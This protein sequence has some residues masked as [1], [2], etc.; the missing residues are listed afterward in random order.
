MGTV[1]KVMF[2]LIILAGGGGIF[3]AISMI[4]AKIDA[5]KEAKKKSDANV[6]IYSSEATKLEQELSAQQN[7]NDNLRQTNKVLLEKDIPELKKLIETEQGKAKK[8]EEERAAAVGGYDKMKKKY[9]E[10]LIPA[11]NGK[12]KAEKT[13]EVERAK[14]RELTKEVAKL[15]KIIAGPTPKTSA[16]TPPPKKLKGEVKNIDPKFGMVR[17]SLGEESAKKGDAYKVTRGG[18]NIGIIVV[19]AVR[20]P[21]SYCK[22]DKAKTVGMD[23]NA[24]TGDIQVGDIVESNRR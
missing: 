13:L 9:D 7:D 19:Q 14:T 24:L 21:V 11:L 20:G 18:K 22:V 16:P 23:R 2:G 5:L 6:G 12:G 3:M 10:E 4:P 17:I 8:A 15:Q 1:T